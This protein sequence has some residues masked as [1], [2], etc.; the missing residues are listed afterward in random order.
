MNTKPD[1]RAS[2]YRKRAEELRAVSDGT[3]DLT[4][5]GALLGLAEKYERMVNLLEEQSLVIEK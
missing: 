5:R 1:G 2:I 3:R 4:S